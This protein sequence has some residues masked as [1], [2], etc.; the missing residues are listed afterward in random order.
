M[1]SCPVATVRRSVALLLLTFVGEQVSTRTYRGSAGATPSLI[2]LSSTWSQGPVCSPLVIHPDVVAPAACDLLQPDLHLSDGC[3]DVIITPASVHNP[4]WM[5][6]P[7]CDAFTAALLQ[8]SADRL[9]QERPHRKDCGAIAP[10]VEQY[11][12]IW[13]R[14]D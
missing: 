3:R 11:T 10:S 7:C 13:L 12:H 4:A 14:M 1:C 9:P 5:T 2:L 8:C 6:P